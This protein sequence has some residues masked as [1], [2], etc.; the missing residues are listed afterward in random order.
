MKPGVITVANSADGREVIYGSLGFAGFVSAGWLI[1]EKFPGLKRPV[2]NRVKRDKNM[3][4][5]NLGDLLIRIKNAAQVGKKTVV[6]SYSQLKE[7][8]AKV[9]KEEGFLERLEVLGEKAEKKL[10]LTLVGEEKRTQTIEVKRISKPGKRVYLQAK[11]IPVFHRGLG[12]VILSTPLGLMTTKTALKK[13]Q[14]GEVICKIVR[15]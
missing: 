9:L 7:S 6:V 14:G 3:M 11:K 12:V 4:S 8:L 2:G 5:D 15:N 1:K 10:V 13:N